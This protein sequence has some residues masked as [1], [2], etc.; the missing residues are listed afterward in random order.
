MVS[1]GTFEARALSTAVRRRGLP[2]G[3]P[4]PLAATVIS[5][6]SL[7]QPLDF[8]A[9]LAA[10]ACLILDHRLWPDIPH[11]GVLIVVSVARRNVATQAGPSY[12]RR[13][14][15]ARLGGAHRRNVV[16]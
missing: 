10:L 11:L 2:E 4:P 12:A 15:A 6:S 1:L 14:A 5:F 16:H 3:S 7:V 13:R 8:L 9:S